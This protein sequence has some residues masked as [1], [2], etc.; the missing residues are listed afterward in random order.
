[1]RYEKNLWFLLLL[2]AATQ[3]HPSAHRPI[4]TAQQHITGVH[5][6]ALLTFLN[7]ELHVLRVIR[8]TYFIKI[9]LF[10]FPEDSKPVSSSRVRKLFR[11]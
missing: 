1:M 2:E 4:S 9:Q 8:L 11:K 10:L 6:S 3:V 7:A 5:I